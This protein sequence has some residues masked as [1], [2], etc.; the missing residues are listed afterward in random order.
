MAENTEFLGYIVESVESDAP[1]KVA[2]K[3]H[4]PRV[5]YTLIR[6]MRHPSNL[7]ALNSR[8]NVCGIKGNYSFTDRRGVLDCAATR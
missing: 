3:L 7:F 1:G 2:Y 8:G 4:G 6:M 5:T